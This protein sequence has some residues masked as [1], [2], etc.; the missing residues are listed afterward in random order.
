MNQVA[1]ILILIPLIIS[2]F[3]YL[4]LKKEKKKKSELIKV[5]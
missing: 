2:I 1:L 3:D 4:I 5:N